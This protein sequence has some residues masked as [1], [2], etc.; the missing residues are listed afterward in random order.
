MYDCQCENSHLAIHLEESKF[1]G[2]SDRLCILSSR[3]FRVVFLIRRV[4]DT[5]S[6]LATFKE[7]LSAFL[8]VMIILLELIEETNLADIK[9]LLNCGFLIFTAI[10][11]CIGSSINNFQVLILMVVVSSHFVFSK[12]GFISTGVSLACRACY[13]C[14]FGIIF[15]IFAHSMLFESSVGKTS[16]EHAY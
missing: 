13:L 4:I 14:Y 7:I 8:A 15:L 3:P 2:H 11:S 9:L 1:C 6:P 10:H 16:P 12:L 5:T